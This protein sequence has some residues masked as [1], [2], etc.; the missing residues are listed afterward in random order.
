M[1]SAEA[2]GVATDAVAPLPRAADGEPVFAEPWQA[3]AFAMTLKLYERGVFSWPEWAATL[4]A[5]IKRA[6]AAGDPDDGSTYYRHWLAA[7][8]RL[9]VEKGWPPWAPSTIAGR[10]GSGRRT[11][12]RTAS[13]SCWRTTLAPPGRV[14]S[15]S[16]AHRNGEPWRL[17]DVRSG[18]QRQQG[19]AMSAVAGHRPSLAAEHDNRRSY[20]FALLSYAFTAVMLG[21]TLPSPMY[22]LYSERLHFSVL[23]TTIIFATYAGG[24]LVTLVVFGSWSDALGRR[25]VL[26]VGV[27]AA[28]ASAVLFLVADSVPLLLVGRALSGLSAACSPARVLRP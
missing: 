25:P 7:I 20:G 1:T 8:E 24:V 4:A 18:M 28:L 12:P 19:D 14:A 26:L 10:H 16:R 23:T 13:R 21:A 3:K 11:R 17:R 2:L 27:V 15:R 9:S 22:T 6:Q 5:E